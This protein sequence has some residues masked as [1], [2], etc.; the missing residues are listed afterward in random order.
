M[1]TKCSKHLSKGGGW[2]N[3]LIHTESA[4]TGF[5]SSKFR[6]ISKIYTLTYW[7]RFPTIPHPT[8]QPQLVRLWGQ[9]LGVWMAVGCLKGHKTNTPYSIHPRK[10]TCPLKRDYINFSRE[11]IFQPL[12]FR[13][14]VSFPGGTLLETF[15]ANSM[16]S[17]DLS[18]HN[19][20]HRV[21]HHPGSIPQKDDVTLSTESTVVASSKR[22]KIP[23]S[24][25][26]KWATQVELH[27]HQIE[28]DSPS[29]NG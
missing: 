9:V 11:Y 19:S 28:P 27:P 18:K 6:W 29:I 3:H 15:G 25:L 24:D 12:I 22:T 10:L 13:G 1:I 2:S 8:K 7:R 4:E 17:S 23:N 20:W 26:H 5:T 14:H 21:N 16:C